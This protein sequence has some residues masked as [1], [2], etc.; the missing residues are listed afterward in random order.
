MSNRQRRVDQSTP[1][2]VGGF[3]YRSLADVLQYVVA[4]GGLDSRSDEWN[5]HDTDVLVVSQWTY[6]VAAAI[7]VGA[8]VGFF[9]LTPETHDGAAYALTILMGMGMAACFVM[10]LSFITAMIGENKVCIWS[11]LFYVRVYAETYRRSSSPLTRYKRR[12]WFFFK[13]TEPITASK[14][15]FLC[16][17]PLHYLINIRWNCAK[18]CRGK[19]RF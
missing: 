4:C 3:K 7:A 13:W 10:A 9:F 18:N 8:A 2:W 5:Y 15:L 14:R 12:H 17:L 1:V 19:D 16:D 11:A 6:C